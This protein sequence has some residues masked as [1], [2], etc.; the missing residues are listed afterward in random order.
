MKKVFTSFSFLFLLFGVALAQKAPSQ[1]V[2]EKESVSP[3]TYTVPGYQTPYPPSNSYTM[4]F[5][6]FSAAEAGYNRVIRSFQVDGRTYVRGEQGNTPFSK[7]TLKRIDN[8]VT[9]N[10][11]TAF[12]EVQGDQEDGQFY[13]APE[14]VNDMEG[15]IN[16]YVF[17]RG[18]DNVLSNNMAT[19]NNVERIDLI[20]ENG[21]KAPSNSLMLNRSGMLVMERG[22]N[23]NFKFAVIKGLSGGEVS[24][25]GELKTA[26]R[27]SAWGGT[28]ITLNTLVVQRDGG[29]EG[30]LRPSQRIDPQEIYGTFITLQDLGVGPDEVF[31]GISLFANDVTASGQAL[32]DLS[33]GF[34]LDTD[35]TDDGGLDFVAGGGFFTVE[36][37]VGGKVFHDAAPD[38]TQ[39][40]GHTG[41]MDGSLIYAHPLYVSLLDGGGNILSTVAVENGAFTFYDVANGDYTLV[42]HQTPEGSNMPS[43]PTGWYSTGEGPSATKDGSADGI[44]HF[45]IPSGNLIS[46]NFGVNST[47]EANDDDFG[48][49]TSTVAYT[50]PGT[51]FENDILNAQPVDPSQVILKVN[52]TEVS[53]NVPLD[54]PGVYLQPDG[55]VTI[56]A[57]APAGTYTLTYTLCDRNQP[58]KCDDAIIT[59]RVKE[60]SSI[61]AED[62][63]FGS[64]YSTSPFTSS[65][66]ILQ[67]DSLNH[68]PVIPSEV[69]WKV[70]GVHGEVALVNEGTGT[71]DSRVKL[72]EDGTVSVEQ[73]TPEGTYSLNYTLCEVADPG[74]CDDAKIIIRVK[75]FLHIVANDDDFGTVSSHVPYVTSAVI[76]AND[77]LDSAPVLP[78]LVDLKVNGVIVDQPVSLQLDGVEN[79][80][81]KL[82]PDGTVHVEQGAVPGT[83]TLPY[84]ICEK[85]NP[86]NCDDAVITIRVGEFDLALE[87][88]VKSGQKAVFKEN[89]EVIFEIVI[90]NEG[91]LDAHD[92][93]VVD[94][95]PD[96]LE[97]LSA[98]WTLQDGKAKLNQT[99]D[100]LAAGEQ[101]IIEIIFKVKSDAKPTL[102]NGAE[103]ASANGGVDKDS[104]FDEDPFNDPE[105]E[106]DK[107]SVQITICKQGGNCLPVKTTKIK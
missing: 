63:D 34:P 7:V 99:I 48:T 29:D 8:S 96:G 74:N 52:G 72:L 49:H 13:L 83:Y 57:G 103:I 11:A 55:K 91:T 65:F 27:S 64:I 16:S 44:I 10:K 40:S 31:Y 93:Q 87:K 53:A 18:S 47:I 39:I 3:H 2:T 104:T 26:E 51:I 69:E 4:N 76:F 75:A 28:G 58:D 1:F 68:S 107:D 23:D 82:Y 79:D 43:L 17:N 22:G 42:L 106:D 88:R 102:R 94:Y 14:Y 105:E 21:I 62:D 66:T 32:V 38:P 15:L 73:G 54:G 85:T 84:T 45:S 37:N 9:G 30:N 100:Q 61:V 90:K 86:T 81:V 80:K 25:L 33:S 35:G 5:G 97:L 60:T 59:I 41:G 98:D 92:I 101:K 50:T 78:E 71:E 20:F 95:A 46:N 67:N 70:N 12:F 6:K 36:N 19:H 77:S 56:E 24:Q 89:D